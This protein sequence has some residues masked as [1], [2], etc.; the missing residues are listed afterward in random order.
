MTHYLTLIE[1]L[2]LHKE[3]INR[4]GGGGLGIRSYSMLDSALNQ[5]KMVFGGEELYP[6]L[7]DKTTALGFSMLKN[8]P[9]IDGNKRIAHAAMQAF[10]ILNG[11]IIKASVGQ[12]ESLI[13]DLASSSIDRD[14]LKEWLSLNTVQ[15]VN[16]REHG[17]PASLERGGKANR[18]I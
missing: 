5:P 16:A 8:H 15:H 7:I 1:T 9:F 17:S 12:Q 2:E 14:T 6:S 4:F 10:L 18:R 11:Y 3:I 13:I